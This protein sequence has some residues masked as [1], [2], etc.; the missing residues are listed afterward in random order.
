MSRNFDF[1]NP[2]DAVLFEHVERAEKYFPT[3][4]STCLIKLRQFAERLADLLVHLHKVPVSSDDLLDR[5]KILER[6]GKMRSMY[7]GFMH[8]IRQFGNRAV[9]RFEGS[10]VDAT[11]QLRNAWHLAIWYEQ[12]HF[13]AEFKTSQFELPGKPPDHE[14]EIR[15]LLAEQEE[16]E[17]QVEESEEALRD[18]E[19]RLAEQQARMSRRNVVPA[20][21]FL[22]SLASLPNATQVS[23]GSKINAF[24]QN[25]RLEQIQPFD[26]AEDAK[27]GWLEAGE[28]HRLVVAISPNSE[29]VLLTW[30]GTPEETET[31]VRNRRVE[32]HPH[33]GALQIYEV[34]TLEDEGRGEPLFSTHT[35]DDLLSCGIPHPLLPGVRAVRDE[36]GLDAIAACLPEEAETALYAL[37]TGM[38]VEAAR[39]EAGVT[40]PSHAFSQTDFDT[41][42]YQQNSRQRFAVIDED[43]EFEQVLKAPF[44]HWRIFLHPSQKKIVQ[45]HAKGPIRVLGGAGTGKTV[46]LLHRVAWLARTFFSPSDKILVTTFSRSLASDLRNQLAML[47]PLEEFQNILV[48]HLHKWVRDYLV[49]HDLPNQITWETKEY[50]KTALKDNPTELPDAFF[51]EEWES[52]IQG[53]GITSKDEYLKARRQGRGTPL[54]RR[55]RL[56]VWEVLERYRQILKEKDLIEWTDAMR[57]TRKHIDE[58]TDSRPFRSVFVDET[59]DFPEEELRL[60]RAMVAKN[61]ND[62]FLAGDPHQRI[63]SR[64]VVLGHCGIDIRGRGF[65][66]KLNYRTTENIRKFGTR[67]LEGLTF[68]DLDAGKDSLDGYLSLRNGPIPEVKVFPTLEEECS[69]VARTV[70]EWLKTTPAESIGLAARTNDQARRYLN[71]LKDAGIPA[72]QVK[73]DT[74]Q[75]ERV[76]VATMHQLKGKEF[77]NVILAGV[78]RSSVP[79]KVSDVRFGDEASKQDFE[80]RER[81]LFYVACTR[82]RDRLVITAPKS[83]TALIGQE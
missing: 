35:D 69:F 50:W 30:L 23:I 58:H 75:G 28:G 29:I 63:F 51:P 37:A 20:Q 18:Y 7:A 53:K 38:S 61:D 48:I 60:L 40:G 10:A 64:P 45:M 54:N 68:D 43:E 33:L 66:L 71:A 42:L 27:F 39:E 22:S 25:P 12:K 65:R 14:K 17:R 52:V 15:K 49:D 41:A 34:T 44:S 56:Q 55:I 1:L 11:K 59:Q 3:D 19:T 76:G 31:W 2:R 80:R 8:E 82:A 6:A 78:S 72:V 57:I 77:S 74:V 24:R 46:A 4:P 36:S 26:H 47:L 16:L 73:Q 21:S 62:M 67:T 13:N 83:L 70:E 32:V 79:H 9:H 5:I 81:C